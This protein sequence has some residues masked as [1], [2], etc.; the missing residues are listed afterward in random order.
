MAGA[1]GP[2]R[3][4]PGRIA[5][6]AV[7]TAFHPGAPPRDPVEAC[8][9]AGVVFAAPENVWLHAAMERTRPRMRPAQR[10]A[11]CSRL[12][13]T[14]GEGAN[15]VASRRSRGALDF[16]IA[17]S[18]Y[19]A[20]QQPYG[21]AAPSDPIR[22]SVPDRSAD[23]HVPE[24]QTGIGPP[25]RP[26]CP[27]RSWLRGPG[28]NCLGR[29]EPEP[30]SPRSQGGLARPH[31][32]ILRVGAPFNHRSPPT[33]LP[34]RTI[35][36]KPCPCWAT[37]GDCRLGSRQPLRALT[38]SIQAGA[39]TGC[40]SAGSLAGRFGSSSADAPDRGP[41]RIRSTSAGADTWRSRCRW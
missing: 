5:E 21:L 29:Q 3:D 12:L 10:L 11:S 35:T 18:V 22:T 25:A 20:N 19:A 39:L 38:L 6:A 17:S 26:A 13:A 34:S 37:K 7:G 36:A 33:C 28:G 24:S 16:G 1:R 41:D 14:V 8:R 2:D 30:R 23:G 9:Q 31:S 32:Q 40:R 15:P 4:V 27:P